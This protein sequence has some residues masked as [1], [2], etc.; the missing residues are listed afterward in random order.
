MINAQ[1]SLNNKLKFQLCTRYLKSQYP[2][3]TCPLLGIYP[4]PFLHFLSFRNISRPLTLPFFFEEYN[5]THLPHS[6]RALW[7][8]IYPDSLELSQE[9]FRPT[10]SPLFL[11]IYP[12]LLLPS[13][14]VVPRL[15][16]LYSFGGYPKTPPLFSRG[17]TQTHTSP[18]ILKTTF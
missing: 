15:L 18:L 13:L 3:S 7:D 14:A 17:N 12:N 8:M 4:D 6:P 5:Q 2:S 16:S 1:S 11:G 9:I 10:P